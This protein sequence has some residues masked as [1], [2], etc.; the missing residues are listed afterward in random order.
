VSCDAYAK[1]LE[2]KKKAFEELEVTVQNKKGRRASHIGLNNSNIYLILD[3][4]D[5]PKNDK[6]VSRMSVSNINDRR[7][8]SILKVGGEPSRRDS[9]L[10]AGGEPNRR[11]SIFKPESDKE[12]LQSS[13]RKDAKVTLDVN[14]TEETKGKDQKK[15]RGKS[16]KNRPKSSRP[17][18]SKPKSINTK[19]KKYELK[20]PNI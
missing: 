9:L 5:S 13:P 1:T 20:K 14:I 19:A 7:R 4:G 16:S 18:S 6:R 8:E 2:S 3:H 15:K 17:K 11:N 10:K 12:A